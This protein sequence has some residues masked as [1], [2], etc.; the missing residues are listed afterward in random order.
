MKRFFSILMML[1]VA[2]SM[3]SCC[4]CRNG[5][6][7]I[8]QLEATKW[9]LVEFGGKTVPAEKSIVLTFNGKEKM[10]YGDAPCNNFFASYAT[11]EG[12]TNNIAISK[13][14]ATR[15][16]CP[17][18]EVEDA[19]V[20]QLESIVTVK[21]EADNILLINANGDLIAIFTIDQT[22]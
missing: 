11:K 2:I 15:M 12:E 8:G 17:D 7:K 4:A 16:F 9:R 18:S 1:I 19:F 5:S 21:V 3:V 14:G 6:P 10:I 13:S 22:K 20:R